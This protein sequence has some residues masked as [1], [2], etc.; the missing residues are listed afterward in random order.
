MS[1]TTLTLVV[2]ARV[3]PTNLL[4]RTGLSVEKVG[5]EAKR[6]E[7]VVLLL[8]ARADALLAGLLFK[9]VEA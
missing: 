3:H 5:V 2:R 9:K 7:R 4:V 1:Y 8:A 6:N